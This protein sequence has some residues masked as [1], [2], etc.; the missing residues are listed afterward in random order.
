M[1]SNYDIIIYVDREKALKGAAMACI[2]TVSTNGK[3][4]VTV[5]ATEQSVLSMIERFVGVLYY[6][7][8]GGIVDVYSNDGE[9][10]R[11]VEVQ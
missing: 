3:Y 10:V 11:R 1:P 9:L 2:H 8:N 4:N 5:S 7:G 6:F